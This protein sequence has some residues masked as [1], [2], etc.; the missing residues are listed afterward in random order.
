MAVCFAKHGYKVVGIDTDQHVLAKLRE[1]QPP[2]HEPNL[3]DYLTDGLKNKNFTVT[4]DPSM[5]SSRR[6]LSRGSAESS[7]VDVLLWLTDP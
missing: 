2:F 5:N 1:G 6:T 3:Q 4:D 7:A